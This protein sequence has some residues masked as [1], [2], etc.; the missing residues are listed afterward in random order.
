MSL[1]SNRR[2]QCALCIADHRS[3]ARGTGA[4]DL[5][6]SIGRAAVLAGRLGFLLGATA[7]AGLSVHCGSAHAQVVINN[8]GAPGDD[9]ANAFGDSDGENGDPGGNSTFTNNAPISTVGTAAFVGSAKGGDGGDGGT[10]IHATAIP[11]FVEL[12]GGDGGDGGPGG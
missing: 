6:L 9:G 11:P 12:E 8:D 10:V 1:F 4:G 5:N 7:L 2:A 3:G